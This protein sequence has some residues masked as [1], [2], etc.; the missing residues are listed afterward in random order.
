M[1]CA[2]TAERRQLEPMGAEE[3]G[4]HPAFSFAGSG[5]FFPFFL[6]FL[7]F[8]PRPIAPAARG[9]A[10]QTANFAVL[11]AFC[12]VVQLLPSALLP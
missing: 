4:A 6:S 8:L 2:Q 3:A 11:I 12:W 7:S 9:P 10:A 5:S 1:G